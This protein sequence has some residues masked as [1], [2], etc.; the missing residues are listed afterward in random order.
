MIKLN[1]T[2][3]AREIKKRKIGNT[4]RYA[5][6]GKSKFARKATAT[7]RTAEIQLGNSK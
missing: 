2:L 5:A 4:D 7:R 6:K 3:L 1:G